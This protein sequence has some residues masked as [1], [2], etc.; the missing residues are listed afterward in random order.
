MSL[1]FWALSYFS[2]HFILAFSSS[3]KRSLSFS[4]LFN[5]SILCPSKNFSLY[6][7]W[8]IYFFNRLFF[9]ISF[10]SYFFMS[11]SL[12]SLFLAYYSTFI[13]PC[14]LVKVFVSWS[15]NFL[16]YSFKVSFYFF[17]VWMIFD[18]NYTSFVHL[19]Y[20]CLIFFD[21]PVHR[22]FILRLNIII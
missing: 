6:L 22:F 3:I 18:L 15:F 9:L 11:Y 10:Y 7:I 12:A 17:W 13:L 19:L 21:D 14:I 20:P 5:S 2:N 16:N 8:S 4:K 1:F